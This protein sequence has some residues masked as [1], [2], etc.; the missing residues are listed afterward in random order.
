MLFFLYGPETYV[1]REKLREIEER[2]EKDAFLVRHFDC[3]NTTMGEVRQEMSTPSLF[4]QKKFLCLLNPFSA[5]EFLREL[6]EEK[7]AFFKSSP[8]GIVF[9]EQRE[10]PKTDPFFLFLKERAQSQC[11]EKLRGAE[12]F[13]FVKKEFARYGVDI[14]REAARALMVFAG[15][16]LWRLSKE[17]QK[18]AAFRKNN[19]PALVLREDV[20]TLVQENADPRIFATIDAIGRKQPALATKL[21]GEHLKAGE[22]PLYLFSMLAYQFRLLLSVKG[23]LGKNMSPA[24]ISRIANL[25]PFVAEK[26]IDAAKLFRVQELKALYRKLFLL[27]LALKTGKGD[28]H[29]LLYLFVSQIH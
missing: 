23:L 13:S 4:Y 16:D 15:D 5:K 20:A 27:D 18:L 12:L 24:R 14:E 29:H 2:F 25:R 11:F 19:V 10:V 7:E 22:A 28:P 17:V 26:A 6:K 21:L 1:A 8:H 3:A 9:F